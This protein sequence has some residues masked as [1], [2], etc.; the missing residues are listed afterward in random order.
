MQVIPMANIRDKKY[1]LR[2]L[3]QRIEAVRVSSVGEPAAFSSLEIENVQS[4]LE[5]GIEFNPEVP[6]SDRRALIWTAIR[7]ATEAGTVNRDSLI[8]ALQQ[9]EKE[10][11]QR[12]AS[13]FILVTSINL[14]STALPPRI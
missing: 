11:L 14:K 1:D 7:S 10:Y 4:V 3:A 5:S 6:L 12:R 2:E 9:A 13:T 8:G